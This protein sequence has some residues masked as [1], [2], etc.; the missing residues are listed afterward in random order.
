MTARLLL[1]HV[2]STL[3]L[4]LPLDNPQSSSSRLTQSTR[5]IPDAGQGRRDWDCFFRSSIADGPEELLPWK[6]KDFY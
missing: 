1:Q 5:E 3:P 4:T 6:K 2:T